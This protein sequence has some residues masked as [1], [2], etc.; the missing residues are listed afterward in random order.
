MACQ[1]SHHNTYRNN[2]DIMTEKLLTNGVKQQALT[3]SL[4]STAFKLFYQ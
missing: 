4:D 3:L 2:K 1:S